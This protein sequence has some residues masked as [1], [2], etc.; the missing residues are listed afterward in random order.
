[1]RLF[2]PE[3]SARKVHEI[4]GF[5][6]PANDQMISIIDMY[7]NTAVTLGY[8]LISIAVVIGVVLFAF[9]AHKHPYPSYFRKWEESMIDTFVVLL[10]IIVIYYLTVPAVGYILHTDRFLQYLNSS[11][12]IEI[13]GHQWYWSYYL[14]CIQNSFFFNFMFILKYSDIDTQIF[15][16][17][18]YKDTIDYV[19]SNDHYVIELDQFMDLDAAAEKRYLEVT[20]VLVLPA[21]EYIRCLITADDVIHSWALPQLGVKVDAIPGRINS[22]I[23][24][25]D[26]F[27][28]FYGQ[29]SEL[30]GVNHAFMPI[31]VEFVNQGMFLDWYYKNLEVRPY[32][33]LLDLLTL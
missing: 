16:D 25:S 20:K 11:F 9:N 10:P 3:L 31:C 21:F 13:I 14:D 8:I 29:C 7:H 30:C 4:H 19:F 2:N 28:T 22:F 32:R 12:T 6:E 26:R 33:I 24:N 23:L 1:M 27:G 5:P 17:K 15:F 18:L